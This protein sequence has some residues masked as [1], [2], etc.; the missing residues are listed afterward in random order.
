LQGCFQLKS[1]NGDSKNP[2]YPSNHTHPISVIPKAEIIK[3]A[4]LAAS[5]FFAAR[6]A[7]LRYFWLQEFVLSAQSTIFNPKL[8]DYEFR[9]RTAQ[10]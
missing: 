5:I 10:N 2:F 3:K 8:A 9:N 7:F 6:N 1:A 4:F